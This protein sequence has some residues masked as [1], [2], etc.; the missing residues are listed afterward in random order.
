MTSQQY[1]KYPGITL[2]ESDEWLARPMALSSPGSIHPIGLGLLLASLLLILLSASCTLRYSRTDLVCATLVERNAGVQRPDSANHELIPL[3]IVRYETPPK[4]TV[5]N[6]W[7]TLGGV[8]AGSAAGIAL[9]VLPGG[10]MGAFGDNPSDNA[11]AMTVVGGLL[12]ELVGGLAGGFGVGQRVLNWS[13][14]GL[15]DLGELVQKRFAELAPQRISGLGP[16]SV[17]RQPFRQPV[18]GTAGWLLWEGG[19]P[20]RWSR[21]VRTEEPNPPWG[22]VSATGGGISY[23]GHTYEHGRNVFTLHYKGAAPTEGIFTPNPPGESPAFGGA[24]AP[25]NLSLSGRLDGLRTWTLN[26]LRSHE[27]AYSLVFTPLGQDAWTGC[28]MSLV[29]AT[30]Y[31]DSTNPIWNVIYEYRTPFRSP[32]VWGRQDWLRNEMTIA[33]ESTAAAVVERLRTDGTVE[34][35]ASFWSESKKV[36]KPEK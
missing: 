25:P 36:E 26:P 18:C 19:R 27:P 22:G 4:M 31:S 8:L 17:E 16:V 10:L 15:P 11:L 28:Y 33:A 35:K 14:A 23:E 7:L 6:P 32:P 24:W 29:Q 30:L 13:S 21:T 34:R 3:T 12:G 5:R 2:T 20:F 1:R 9:G